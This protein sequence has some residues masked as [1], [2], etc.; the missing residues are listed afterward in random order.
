M[1]A[2]DLAWAQS[3]S[4][5]RL[6]LEAELGTLLHRVILNFP[7]FRLF[8]VLPLVPMVKVVHGVRNV[9]FVFLMVGHL[10]GCPPCG[11][12]TS[13]VTFRSGSPADRGMTRC[14]HGGVALQ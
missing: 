10:L 6:S 4:P 13:E 8:L 7:G 11:Q 14:S 2:V 9:F 5:A 12:A 1:E 3:N